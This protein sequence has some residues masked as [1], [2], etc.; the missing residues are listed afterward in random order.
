MGC[1]RLLPIP[2]ECYCTQED[3]LLTQWNDDNTAAIRSRISC[4]RHD[5]EEC[6][7]GA[8]DGNSA[9]SDFSSILQS[10]TSDYCSRSVKVRKCFC[11]NV[12]ASRTPAIQPN[13][14]WLSQDCARLYRAY[15]TALSTFNRDKSNYNRVKIS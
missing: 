9:V 7:N 2:G 13:K 5:L 12:A 11:G 8:R 1:N 10:I 6:I 4:H 15:K 3:V 14:L